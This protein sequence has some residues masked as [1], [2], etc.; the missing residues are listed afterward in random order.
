M[1]LPS[2]VLPLPLWSTAWPWPSWLAADLPGLSRGGSVPA[3]AKGSSFC[4]CFSLTIWGGLGGRRSGKTE[5][6][7][8]PLP[9]LPP[10]RGIGR[11]QSRTILS[12]R[13]ASHPE[14]PLHGVPGHGGDLPVLAEPPLSLYQ[15]SSLSPSLVQP[16]LPVELNSSPQPLPHACPSPSRAL[17][18]QR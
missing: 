16:V 2:P 15:S 7:N 3:R 13:E 10:W 9:R 1:F 4:L 11:V 17:G 12:P 8:V 14:G 6:R 18:A 5:R